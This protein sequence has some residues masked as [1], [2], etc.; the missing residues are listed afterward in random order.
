[1]GSRYPAPFKLFTETEE[2]ES[3]YQEVLEMLYGPEREWLFSFNY[4]IVYAQASFHNSKCIIFQEEL[5]KV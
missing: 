1:M 4:F 3:K 5:L 2:E